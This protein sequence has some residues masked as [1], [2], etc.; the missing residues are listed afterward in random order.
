VYVKSN[1]RFSNCTIKQDRQL[2]RRLILRALIFA[3][4]KPEP[5]RDKKVTLVPWLHG[6]HLLCPSVIVQTFYF[7]VHATSVI[8]GLASSSA[9][10]Y[11]LI[12]LVAA[13]HPA[14]GVSEVIKQQ[15][16][17]NRLQ[18]VTASALPK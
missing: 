7:V 18:D 17:G 12:N 13:E 5:H 8:T 3:Q 16:A 10:W 9:V 2:I 15:M 1:A 14:A 11:R 6:I 4:A